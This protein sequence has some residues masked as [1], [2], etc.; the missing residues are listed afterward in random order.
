MS[1]A[2]GRTLESDVHQSRSVPQPSDRE[3]KLADSPVSNQ[4]DPQDLSETS[5][6]DIMGRFEAELLAIT[7]KQEETSENEEVQE[8]GRELE[9]E[10]CIKEGIL[11]KSQ[12]R[13][14]SDKGKPSAMDHNSSSE[15]SDDDWRAKVI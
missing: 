3:D 6:T 14:R 11:R 5:E 4:S 10:S 7:G 1:E 15:G 2:D 13:A 8:D 9:I 12:K